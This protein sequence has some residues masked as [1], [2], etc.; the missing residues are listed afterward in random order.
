VSVVRTF[1]RYWDL[2]PNGGLRG[3]RSRRGTG[4]RSGLAEQAFPT[5]RSL[6]RGIGGPK[7]GQG[8]DPE[9]GTFLQTDPIGSLDYVNLYEYVGLEPG[10]GTDP[11][12]MCRRLMFNGC[13]VTGGSSGQPNSGVPV[14]RPDDARAINGH[15]VRGD[16]SPR[17]SD[18]RAVDISD[19]GGSIQTM[20]ND[21]GSQLHSAIA[22]AARTGRAVEVNITD[23]GGGGF[24]G[25]TSQA[26]KGGIGRFSVD[27]AGQVRVNGRGGWVLTGTVTGRPDRQDYPND[28]RRGAIA[29]GATNALGT[30]QGILGGQDYDLTFFGSQTIE[31]RGHIPSIELRRSP[32][33][34]Q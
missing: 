33:G 14:V 26:Q 31:A 4:G 8:Y 20:A 18:F 32:S 17:Q 1:G 30:M 5:Q 11:T 29:N 27:V 23:I 13:V 15:A 9:T 21:R 34:P 10:N 24:G 25:A 2:M 7:H 19:L 6:I 28:A 12:G 22:R 3:C 16:G